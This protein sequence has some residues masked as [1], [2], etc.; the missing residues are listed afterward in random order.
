MS[1]EKRRLV[2]GVSGASG[3]PLALACLEELRRHPEWEVH[4]IVSAGAAETL[5]WESSRSLEE[6]KALAHTCYETGN[7]GAGPASG[8]FRTEGMLIAPCSMKTLAWIHSGYA[9]NLLLL[10]A[11]V[12][13]KEGRRL[14]LCPR[15]SPLSAIHLR[16]MQELAA[17]GAVIAPPVITCYLR[18]CSAQG[19]IRQCAARLLE[20]FGIETGCVQRW[21]DGE[22][23]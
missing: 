21:K 7:I 18:D 4:L 13:L 1:G 6:M 16:N 11:D 9:G 3:A 2:V 12:T 20:R 8:T 10:A 22:E 23:E 15:E 5:R 17:M 14:V 19:M